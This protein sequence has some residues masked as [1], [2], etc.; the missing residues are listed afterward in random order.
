MEEGNN[1][2]IKI[3]IIGPE[4]TGKSTLCESLA[5]EYNTVFVPE[6]AREYLSNLGRKYTYDDVLYIAHQQILLEKEY[7]KKANKILFCD[8]NLITIK[9]WLQVVF[10][11]IPDD[12]KLIST[13]Q[14]YDYTLLMDIDTPWVAD[15]LREHPNL[16]QELLSLNKV[17]LKIFDL[18]YILINGSFDLRFKNA[19][20]ILEDKFK[21]K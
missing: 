16:R 13:Q 12:F 21:L 4:S 9:I 2:I 19:C 11:C 15:P 8:T 14:P 20:Q 17:E 7:E 5:K 10:N 6:F 18:P 1:K 3:A